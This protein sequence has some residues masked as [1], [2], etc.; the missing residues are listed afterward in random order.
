MKKDLICDIKSSDDVA[1]IGARPL[2][3][4]A[5][6]DDEKVP[7]P[8]S[9][10]TFP[11]SGLGASDSRANLKGGSLDGGKLEA[12]EGEER[13]LIEDWRNEVLSADTRIDLPPLKPILSPILNEGE[14][15]I[16][17]AKTGVGKSWFAMEM[18][19]VIAEGG[20]FLGRYSVETPRR[21][22]YV[23]GEMGVRP[24]QD[25]LDKMKVHTGNLKYKTCD[26]PNDCKPWDFAK[27]EFQN[28][29]IR[30]VKEFQSD[31][32]F[33]DNLTTL[34]FADKT[35]QQESWIIMQSFILRLRNSGLAVVIVDH[36]GKGV[37]LGPRGTS[38]KTDIMQTVIELETPVDYKD[39]DGARFNVHFRKH[40]N[41]FG[42]DAKPFEAWLTENGWKISDVKEA[43]KPDRASDKEKAF[44]MFD[45]GK[46]VQEVLDELGKPQSTVYRWHAEWEGGKDG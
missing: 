35:N 11:E 19:K 20:S 7:F 9:L 38:A 36:S 32:A 42:D 1:K 33:L 17:Y 25:R 45:E 39:E 5:D 16:I 41:F 4:P 46:S 8:G 24:F 3:A 29:L 43:P 2:E 27:E 23:D 6:S 14:A 40:R 21:V 44:S 26:F 37:G 13:P 31:V 12:Q 10:K 15:M 30:C 34:Y 18:G 28:A 22:F